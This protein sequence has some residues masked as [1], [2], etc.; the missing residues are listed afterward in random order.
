MNKILVITG[1]TAVGKT[2]LSI[3]L[4][5]LLNG[6]IVS[7]DSMQ[8]YETLDIGTAKPSFEERQGIPHHMLDVCPPSRR[9]SVADYVDDSVR[10]IDDILSRGKLPII[11]G[12]TGLYIDHLIYETDFNEGDTDLVLRDQLS[13]IAK[14]K[15]GAELKKILAEFD[16]ETA[17]R[18]HD[19]DVK[20]LIRSI[21]FYRVTGKTISEHNKNNSFGKKRY[22]AGFFVLT[23][24]D[25]AVLYDR[26][27]LRVDMMIEQGLLDEA[28]RVC[29]SDWFDGS[30][31]AQAIGYK[32]F[33]PYFNADSSLDSC[34][35]L[36]KQHSRNYAKRQLTWFRAKKDA[37][38]IDILDRVNPLEAILSA[39]RKIDV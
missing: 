25:R 9:Y 39:E 4:A 19:N 18:L 15:G 37:V 11:V 6:E 13:E 27:D 14:E 2:A 31:A 23:C 1:P 29:S 3:S 34:V 7:A 16:P 26:I 28:K 32:E 30:T 5:R 10:C 17:L 24:S 12:G 22:D 8:V 36:L 21:E 38:F 20:R 35:E 33:V